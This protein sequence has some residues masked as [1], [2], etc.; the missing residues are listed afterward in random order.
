MTL[1]DVFLI[2]GTVDVFDQEV[3]KKAIKAAHESALRNAESLETLSREGEV[4]NEKLGRKEKE[5]PNLFME[6]LD[7]VSTG[8]LRAAS[9]P[10]RTPP[11]V[12]HAASRAWPA[13]YDHLGDPGRAVHCS[14]AATHG[15]ATYSANGHARCRRRR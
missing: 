13:P 10:P 3:Q 12:R 15:A 2:A 6:K 9:H 4:N 5:Q 7:Q 1:E 11:R 14:S 8:W